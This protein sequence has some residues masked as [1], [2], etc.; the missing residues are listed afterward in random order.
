MIYKVTFYFTENNFGY[1]ESYW[2][3]V[4]SGAGAPYEQVK[5]LAA[6]RM[7]CMDQYTLLSGVRMSIVGTY[8][9]SLL[10]QPGDNWIPGTNTVFKLPNFGTYAANFS[11]NFGDQVR[12]CLQ[13][14]CDLPNFRKSIRYFGGVP[15]GIAGT[16][17][18]FLD[19]KTHPAWFKNVYALEALIQKAGWG[20]MARSMV[21]PNNV[22]LVTSV[23]VGGSTNDLI[24]LV[25][26]GGAA[27]VGPGP[28]R[29]QV[30][31]FRPPPC[32]RDPSL[33]GTWMVDSITTSTTPPAITIFLSGTSGI[34][35]S[36][37]Q[38]MP[39]SS[40][41]YIVPTFTPI[42]GFDPIRIGIHKRGRPSLTPRGRQL[43]RHTLVC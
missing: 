25:V 23:V 14:R 11:P 38:R 3:N 42:L 41:Q 43:K 30:S 13:V 31:R 29:V 35:P 27:P 10:L 1:T 32:T 17:G 34:L 4:S 12:S 20:V 8:R 7:A 5:A 37:V 9:A 26:A 2:L 16:D 21:A 24:G 15:L 18:A 39:T 28:F 22:Q 36:A 40:V 19:T 6:A 33:N